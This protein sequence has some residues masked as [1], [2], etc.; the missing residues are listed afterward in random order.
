MYID[1][2]L[3]DETGYLG[4]YNPPEDNQKEIDFSEFEI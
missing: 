4:E 3:E 2:I 1:I